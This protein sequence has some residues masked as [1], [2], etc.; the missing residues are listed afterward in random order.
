VLAQTSIA[1]IFDHFSIMAANGAIVGVRAARLVS[2]AI[3]VES[4]RGVLNNIDEKAQEA[5]VWAQWYF[6]EDYWVD[7]GVTK[8]R[9]PHKLTKNEIA[10]ITL[11]TMEWATSL[12]TELNRRLREERHALQPFFEYLKLFLTA[13]YKLPTRKM[14][15]YRGMRLGDRYVPLAEDTLTT[16]WGFTSTSPCMRVL[17]EP[18][19][20]G[21]SGNRVAFHI[22]GRG[23]D[24]CPYSYIPSENESL[25]LP[26]EMMVKGVVPQNRLTIVQLEQVDDDSSV[27]DFAPPTDRIRLE[28]EEVNAI[29]QE[30]RRRC[31][32]LVCLGL[33]LLAWTTFVV[34]VGHEVWIK[35]I[36]RDWKQGSPLHKGV[37]K[38][39][40]AQASG[41]LWLIGGYTYKEQDGRN[42]PS[43]MIQRYDL[44]D[45]TWRVDDYY[46]LAEPLAGHAV[47]Q[48]QGFWVVTGGHSSI[49]HKT[50]NV[51]LSTWTT[52][53]WG[54]RIM[55][56]T[57]KH[58][59]AGHC[60]IMYKNK[61]YVIG[62]DDDFGG[63][64]VE[65]FDGRTWQE[66]HNLTNSHTK[67]FACVNQYNKLFVFGGATRSVEYFDGNKWRA[68]NPLNVASH[69]E[70]IN[71]FFFGEKFYV[72][73]SS[74]IEQ[75]T[76]SDSEGKM[77]WELRSHRSSYWIP[78]QLYMAGCVYNTQYWALGGGGT[79]FSEPSKEVWTLSFSSLTR[80]FG[81]PR[82][83]DAKVTPQSG[84]VKTFMT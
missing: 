39:A 19:F 56:K 83:V 71:V 21:Q 24:I 70:G 10:A 18:H 50:S 49:T 43:K 59:R 27:F 76:W 63:R 20:L 65:Y 81:A 84:A 68:T 53:P 25:I 33:S 75:G 80:W 48:W 36:G 58:S 45:K 69:R 52:P 5:L 17:N 8:K 30:S 12:Y 51:Q 77:T 82:P 22:N 29:K 2:L 62:G 37:S 13:L 47:V 7:Q 15:L 72:I 35:P 6:D 64:S 41:T 1:I 23:I 46:Q 61:L 38:S 42:H 26:A 57:M 40:V 55:K 16:F 32:I 44:N 28:D 3:A 73:G 9:N 4:L 74:M 78:G 54:W 34:L 79:R 14:M 66:D 67:S 31:K 11:Y 60:S